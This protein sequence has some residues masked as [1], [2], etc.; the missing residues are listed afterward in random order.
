[1]LHF[2]KTTEYAFRIMSF[3]AQ[4]KDKLY[5]SDDV[6]EELQ[7]PFRYLRRIMTRLSREGLLLSIKGKYGGFRIEKELGD[8]TLFDIVQ[9]IGENKKPN[10]CFFGYEK[11]P[12]TNK[13]S[14][15]DNWSEV[16][17]NIDTVLKSTTLLK[18]KEHSPDYFSNREKKS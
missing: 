11:C 16:K 15:H 1:M 4:D 7:I 6:Y 8:I 12:L 17:Q 14:M 10:E 18:I 5:R 13:C 2:N 3:M 9:A